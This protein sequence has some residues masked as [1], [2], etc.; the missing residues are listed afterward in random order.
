MTDHMVNDVELAP[1]E[2]VRQAAC[3]F[4]A[5]LAETPQFNAFEEAADR[6]RHDEVAQHLIEA[7]QSKQRSLQ[8]V[9][10][11]NTASAGDRA[12]LERL[13]E[14]FSAN[15]SV[16]AYLRAQTE[17]GAICQVANDVLSR[18]IGLSFAAS[19]GPGCCC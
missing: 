5:A 16:V 7:Y 17:L 6:L 3:D 13:R 8:V 10:M 12:D 15:P 4:A 1:P 18:H 2:V 9:L 11:L 14:A 19:C